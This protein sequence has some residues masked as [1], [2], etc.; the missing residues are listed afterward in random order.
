[1]FTRTADRALQCTA[2]GAVTIAIALAAL[3]W[4]VDLRAARVV[5]ARPPVADTLTAD[6]LTADALAAAAFAR[7]TSAPA[8]AAARRSFTAP[9]RAPTTRQCTRS[10]ES[11]DGR[12]GALRK[13]GTARILGAT[14]VLYIDAPRRSVRGP[15]QVPARERLLFYRDDEYLGAYSFIAG[16]SPK[17]RVSGSTVAIVG[18][19]R[20]AR[21]AHHPT[22]SASFDLRAGPPPSLWFDGNLLDLEP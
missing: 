12:A 6:A 11:R 2:Q 1:M 15:L 9:D 3:F 7:A 17:V 13:V 8:S 4:A 10:H 18:R 5:T 14:Y 19:A 22:R 21:G 20:D 16:T